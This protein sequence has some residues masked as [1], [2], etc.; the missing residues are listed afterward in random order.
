MASTTH[1]GKW[2]LL[3]W[4][5]SAQG[6][7]ERL[8]HHLA[9]L[10]SP[11]AR[12]VQAYTT[13]VSVTM[14]LTLE[15]IGDVRERDGVLNLHVHLNQHWKDELRT[16]EPTLFA[17]A[18]SIVVDTNDVWVPQIT[19]VNSELRPWNSAAEHPSVSFDSRGHA[20]ISQLAKLGIRCEFA[21][22]N[23]PFDLQTCKVEIESWS[24]PIN[25]MDLNFEWNMEP[26]ARISPDFYSVEWELVDHN[27][28]FTREVRSYPDNSRWP[29]LTWSFRI[30]RSSASYILA[31]IVPMML[32]TFVSILTFT[33]TYTAAPARVFLSVVAFLTIVTVHRSFTGNMPKG[34]TFTWLDFFALGCMIFTILSL[35]GSLLVMHLL[36][37]L[38]THHEPVMTDTDGGIDGDPVQEAA[39][40]KATRCTQ[41]KTILMGSE[42]FPHTSASPAA[43][44]S[45]TTIMSVVATNA[46]SSTRGR[47]NTKLDT[48]AKHIKAEA[49]FLRHAEKA[50]LSTK[51][52]TMAKHI[53]SEIVFLHRAEKAIQNSFEGRARYFDRLF[54]SFL[55]LG[56]MVFSLIMLVTAGR[57]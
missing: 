4:L 16:W 17:N 11:N 24:Y 55:A 12:P 30:Q 31:C 5:G 40:L 32:S 1:L 52:D 27:I 41:P 43:E 20:F 21:H 7:E 6:S 9:T 25:Q 54:G 8:I 35:A 23:Y 10:S 36:V 26:P 51:L 45:P 53:K 29:R 42:R 33:V 28:S 19:L 15:T 14:G 2:L 48:M 57:R 37:A 13:P 49:S 22:A 56:F 44:V 38:S 47:L 3:S 18:S 50:R 46:R 39:K 34:S